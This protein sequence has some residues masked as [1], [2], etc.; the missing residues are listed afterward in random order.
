MTKE[1][2]LKAIDDELAA[3]EKEY[4]EWREST[5]VSG[6]K[7]NVYQQ[8]GA[9][10]VREKDYQAKRSELER[11]KADVIGVSTGVEAYLNHKGGKREKLDFSKLDVL[12]GATTI[13]N[14]LTPLG[15]KAL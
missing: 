5:Q 10:M 3:L 6:N 2:T 1:E 12:D 9:N 4:Q 14:S 13:D 8:V 15:G 7:A 11:Q